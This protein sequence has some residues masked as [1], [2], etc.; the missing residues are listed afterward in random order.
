M[1]AGTLAAGRCQAQGQ[2]AG[3]PEAVYAQSST[4]TIPH[5]P[6]PCSPRSGMLQHQQNML[7][8]YIRTGTYYA[9]IL[10]NKADFEGG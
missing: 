2:L 6:P 7:Q 8:D 1:R 9:A 10:E 4:P 5:F 3:W